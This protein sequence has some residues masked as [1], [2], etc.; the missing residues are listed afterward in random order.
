MVT[1]SAGRKG[2]RY[3]KLSADQKAKHLPCWLCGQPINYQATYPE[4]DSFTVDHIKSWINHPELRQDPSNLASA[5]ARCNQ[6]KGKGEAPVSLGTF[7]EE[8]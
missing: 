8:W 6:S 1:K 2:A 4:P 7:S 5:H 3:R